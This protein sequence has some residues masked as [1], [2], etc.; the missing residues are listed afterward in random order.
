MKRETWNGA[1]LVFFMFVQFGSVQNQTISSTAW[2]F[3]QI[4]QSFVNMENSIKGQIATLQPKINASIDDLK[5]NG[6]FN[7]IVSTLVTLRTLLTSESTVMSYKGGASA[8]TCND[9]TIRIPNI[10]FDIQ[11][12]YKI[13]SEVAVNASLLYTQAAYL[14]A[15]FGA[16]YW[17]LL[18]NQKTNL[19]T[20]VNLALIM[21]NEYN[22]YSLTLLGSIAKYVQIYN[23]FLYCK[24]TFC[25]CPSQLSSSALSTFATF[26]SVIKA[27]EA[28]ID[29][30][31]A[32]IRKISADAISKANA[33]NPDLKKN[34]LLLTLTTTLDTIS[35]LFQGYILLTTTDVITTTKTCDDAALKVS[36]LQYKYQAYAQ[37][38]VEAQKNIT[39]IWV[40][41]NSLSVYYAA[42][43]SQLSSSQASSVQEVVT[44]ATS[45]VEQYRQYI[46][47]LITAYVKFYTLSSEARTAKTAACDCKQ[48]GDSSSTAGSK[49]YY[50]FK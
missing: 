45:L 26:D 48:T 6:A 24:N 37:L 11:Y 5:S 20:I 27:T 31:E 9:V 1:F 38:S 22:T 41:L 15:Y 2:K 34:S 30:M 18:D 4:E 39:Y 35:T 25:S 46:L 33:V 23:E 16:A 50:N 7:Y 8:M 36:F 10:Q 32:N 13:N 47:N 29:T 43:K 12:A 21:F 19:Q 3:Q 28:T 44:L 17:Y 40:Q 42:Y 14:N 49:T